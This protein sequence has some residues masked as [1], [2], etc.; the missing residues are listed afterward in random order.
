M[1]INRKKKLDKNSPIARSFKKKNISAV[2]TF[3]NNP[4]DIQNSNQS[5]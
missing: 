2:K 3:A 5:A 4:L 1:E